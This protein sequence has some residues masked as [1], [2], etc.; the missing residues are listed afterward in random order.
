MSSV[1]VASKPY[2]GT[3]APSPPSPR[4]AP[5]DPVTAGDRRCPR[6]RTAPPSP[7]ISGSRPSTWAA[8]VVS[9]PEPGLRLDGIN[10]NSPEKKGTGTHN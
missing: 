7:A 6:E 3:S 5:K 9:V 1:R 8:K 2:A 10:P 4:T